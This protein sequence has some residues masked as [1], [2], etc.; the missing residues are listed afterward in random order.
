MARRSLGGGKKRCSKGKSCGATC[1]LRSKICRKD[2][3]QDISSG[4]SQVRDLVQGRE[5][6][7]PAPKAPKEQKPAT[8]YEKIPNN[9]QDRQYWDR[10]VEKREKNI[11][12]VSSDKDYDRGRLRE[13]EA[14]VNYTYK[15]VD[16]N[17]HV[18]T[19]GLAKLAD[20]MGVPVSEY[21]ESFRN[22][23]GPNTPFTPGAVLHD[24]RNY[25]HLDA[26][27]LEKA[28]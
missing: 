24:M 20:F 25:G 11:D 2:T 1:I 22:E 23:Y 12:S 5:K 18:S 10:Q 7:K 9:Q 14:V 3:N 13:A 4:A 28:R 16:A 19:K 21:I 27:I 26:L 8:K 17:G 15:S 6:P